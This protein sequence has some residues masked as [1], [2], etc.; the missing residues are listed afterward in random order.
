LDK[1]NHT[2]EEY[3][4]TITKYLSW[5]MEKPGRMEELDNVYL[6]RGDNF[7]DEK[8]VSTISS[9]L[10]TSLPKPEKPLLAYAKVPEEDSVKFSARTLDMMT[11]KGLDLGEIMRLA[12]EKF[13]GRGGGHNIAAGA[14]VPIEN[15]A[16]FIRYV[17][18]LVKQQLGGKDKTS[19]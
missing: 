17:N 16:A 18:E 19:L 2:L 10:S 4:R 13:E 14:Q 9:I 12:A 11:A 3:R 6:V 7:I 5:I 8:V 15:V 1:A